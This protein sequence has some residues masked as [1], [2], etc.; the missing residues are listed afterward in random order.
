MTLYYYNFVNT[1]G[2]D[3]AIVILTLKGLLV[4]TFL[5]PTPLYPLDISRKEKFNYTKKYKG[6][7]FYLDRR[8]KGSLIYNSLLFSLRDANTRIRK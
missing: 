4:T 7:K 3:L 1:T 8:L 5:L 6:N 2:P